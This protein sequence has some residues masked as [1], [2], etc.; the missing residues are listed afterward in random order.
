MN[1]GRAE[2]LEEAPV[3]KLIWKLSLPAMVGMFVNGLYNLVDTIY[4]GRGVGPMGIAGLSVAFPIQM[5]MGGFGAM[6][7]IGTAS[8]ISRSLGAKD[9][10]KAQQALGNNLFAIIFLG[11]IFAVLGE[12][13]LGPVLRAF[14]ASE[15]IL[16]YAGSYMRIIFAGAPLV[17]FCMSMNNVIRSEGAARVAMISMVVG[18]VVNFILDPIFIFG[19]DMG[20]QGAALATVLARFFVIAWIARFFFTGKSVIAFR[21]RDM[22]PR[23][24]VLWEIVSVG[25]PALVHHASSSFVFGLMN[26]LLGFYGGNLAISVFGVNNRVIIFSA[27]PA[28]GIAQGMQPILGYNYGARRFRRAV[29]AISTSTR[30]ALAFSTGVTALILLFP[31]PILRIFTTDPEMLRLGPSVLRMMVAGFFLAG[32]NKVAGTVFQALGKALPSFILNTARPILIFVPLLLIL[33]R[34]LGTNGVWL[35]FCLADILTFLVTLCFVVPQIRALAAMET[36]TER[37]ESC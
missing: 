32:Y 11:T 3:S 23:V 25:F 26:K 16:P 5:L 14:G 35:S 30:I 33:P 27:M 24:S 7:G 13:F 34:F 22:A 9:Y 21:I 12:L 17:L 28:V 1:S 31:G 18:A 2:M 20:I 15:E 29:E 4:I 19:L 36:P 10:G 37:C 6:L 8:L